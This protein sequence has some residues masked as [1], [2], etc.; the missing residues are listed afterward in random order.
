MDILQKAGLTKYEAMAYEGLIKNKSLTGYELAKIS[1][2]PSSKIYEVL[3]KLVS[4]G[5]VSATPGK[6]KKYEAVN[7]KTG[8]NNLFFEKIEEINKKRKKV[9]DYF[10]KHKFEKG[11]EIVTVH[12]SDKSRLNIFEKDLKNAKKYYYSLFKKIPSINHPVTKIIKKKMDEGVDLKSVV[13]LTKNNKERLKKWRKK[14]PETYRT[15]SYTEKTR[16]AVSDDKIAH[17]TI[18]GPKKKILLRIRDIDF[19]KIMKKTFLE[20]WKKAKS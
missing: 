16:F 10:K 12:K 2:V 11:E 1:K 5:L 18:V 7:P 20:V 9:N 4:K 13:T 15:S 17:I 3:N 14:F 19:A 6:P 8:L